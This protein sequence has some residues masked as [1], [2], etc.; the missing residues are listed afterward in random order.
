MNGR[1]LNWDRAKQYP[2]GPANVASATGCYREKEVEAERKGIRFYQGEGKAIIAGL[3]AGA[4]PKIKNRPKQTEPTKG[5]VAHE[6]RLAK[7]KEG[8]AARKTARAARKK[9]N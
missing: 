6:K 8:R 9:S 5:R 3:K 2:T 7:W 1:R 4:T